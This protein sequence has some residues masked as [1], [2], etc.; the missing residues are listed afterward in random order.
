MTKTRKSR[1][2]RAT[3]TGRQKLL[4]AK[5]SRRNEKGK[6]WTY[7]DVATAAQVDEKT[8]QR[9]FYGKPKDREYAIAIVQALDLDITEVVDPNEWNSVTQTSASVS[10]SVTN[11]TPIQPTAYENLSRKGIQRQQFKGRDHELTD[12]HHLLQQ[13]P[14]VAITA[15]VVGMGGVGKTELA[16]QY[17][18]EHLT[19]YQGGVCWL[20]A[21]D[22]ASKLVEFARPYFFPSIN[23]DNLSPVERVR[24]CWQHWAEG[25]VLLIVDNVTNYKQH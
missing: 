8:V 4:Q 24:Y 15:A 22:F 10:E 19:T 23:L 5:A 17:A 21:N 14:Q 13:N 3:E 18:R 11:N 6:P 9:F 7:F 12:L 16:I 1:G 20:P 2:V 25:E